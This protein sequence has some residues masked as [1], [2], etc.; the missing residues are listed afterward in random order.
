MPEQPNQILRELAVSLQRLRLAAQRGMVVQPV[1][2]IF[3]QCTSI[4]LARNPVSI[5][6]PPERRAQ[7]LRRFELCDEAGLAK[8]PAFG[9][10]VIP[11]RDP[12]CLSSGIW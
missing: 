10:V 12:S 3:G 9:F 1:V 6:V 8:L 4:A 5:L 2:E 11:P 7:C